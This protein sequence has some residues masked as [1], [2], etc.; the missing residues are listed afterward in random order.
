MK[1]FK[2]LNWKKNKNECVFH[3]LTNC[4]KN[5]VIN[6][7]SDNINIELSDDYEDL[8]IKVVEFS[9]DYQYNTPKEKR[10]KGKKS[11]N[12]I[13]KCILVGNEENINKLLFSIGWSNADNIH[14]YKN[15]L[16]ENLIDELNAIKWQIEEYLEDI[17]KLKQ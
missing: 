13:D 7:Y 2:I 8:K 15:P 3:A 1:T 12:E 4:G 14:V 6:D 16:T 9:E 5:L 10:I 11:E 17:K